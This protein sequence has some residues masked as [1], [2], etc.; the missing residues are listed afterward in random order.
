[1]R[2]KQRTVKQKK[3]PKRPAL[4]MPISGATRRL[5][6]DLLEQQMWCFGCDIRRVEGNL[7]L[8]YGFTRHRPPEG[9]QGHSCYI[10][11]PEA[12]CQI[13]LWGS[14]LF[15]GDAQLG[16]LFL[17]RYDFQPKLTALPH[18][19]PSGIAEAK[20]PAAHKPQTPAEADCAANLASA[21]LRWLSQYE[22][23]VQAN[24]GVSYR[25][26][27]IA[28]WPKPKPTVATEAIATTW[29]SLADSWLAKKIYT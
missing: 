20:P 27:C 3:Q 8:E 19:S 9:K 29:Q 6:R 21:A 23:W 14:G 13:G 2:T 4:K 15:Y 16:G 11:R 10:F 7:L 26:D 24:V 25:Q 28:N 22:A 17:K 1:M 12:D 18:L 5:G